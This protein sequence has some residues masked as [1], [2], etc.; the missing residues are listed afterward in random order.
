MTCKCGNEYCWA[1]LKRWATHNYNNCFNVAESTYELR[2]ST[3]SRFYNKALNHR[4]Q[5]NQHSFC[6]LETQIQRSKTCA[7]HYSLILSTYIDLNTLAEFV[8]VLLQKRHIDVNIRGVLG[9]T[10]NRLEADA[11]KMK[12]QIEDEQ[13][14][15]DHI[16]RIRARLQRTLMS[17]LHMKKNKVFM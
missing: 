2:S 8:Y 4:R 9:R 15:L 11:F 17:L 10:A 6:L 3:R 5:R 13:I 14:K 7:D 12:V 1:C 16:E